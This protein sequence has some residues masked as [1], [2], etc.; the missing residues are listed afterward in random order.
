MRK[1]LTLFFFWMAQACH[2]GHCADWRMHDDHM[3]VWHR[4]YT[5]DGGLVPK[6]LA[7]T[8]RVCGKTEDFPWNRRQLGWGPAKAPDTLSGRGGLAAYL[9]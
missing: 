1:A 8:C 5:P 3:W 2:R 6:Y 7:R 9:L 4:V